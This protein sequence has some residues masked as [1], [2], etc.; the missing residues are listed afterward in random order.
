[1]PI[2]WLVTSKVKILLFL[3]MLSVFGTICRIKIVTGALDFAKRESIHSK[4]VLGRTANVE[5]RYYKTTWRLE[6]EFLVLFQKHK[7]KI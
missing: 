2:Q 5:Q 3:L 6:F 7:C 4:A 1:M